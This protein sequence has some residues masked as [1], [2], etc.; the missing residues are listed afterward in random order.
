MVGVLIA[1]HSNFAKGIMDAVEMIM[2]DVSYVACVSLTNNGGITEFQKE[3]NEKVSNL[4]S[5]CDEILILVDLK[6]GTPYNVSVQYLEDES[7]QADCKVVTGLNLPMLLEVL[8]AK[9]SKNLK[10][11]ETIAFQAGQQGVC[12]TEVLEDIDDDDEEL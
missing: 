3:M 12:L 8:A 11:L 9:G 1:S 6:F 5:E 10:E 4:N 2:G 7:I